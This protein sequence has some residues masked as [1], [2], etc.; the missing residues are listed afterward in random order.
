MKLYECYQKQSVFFVQIMR[1]EKK[2]DDLILMEPMW[3]CE[4]TI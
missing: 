2:K 3:N 1:L 4:I